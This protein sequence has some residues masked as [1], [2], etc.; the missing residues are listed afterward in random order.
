MGIRRDG[1]EPDELRPI[2]FTRDFT[3]FAKGSVLVEFGRTAVLCT[4]SVEEA[5]RRGCGARAAA[6]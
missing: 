4:A 3:E 6:G 1:R 5:V 2:V